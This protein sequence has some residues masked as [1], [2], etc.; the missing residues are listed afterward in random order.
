LAREH[1]VPFLVAA[2]FS[3]VD[4]SIPDGSH[5]PIEERD[6]AEVTHLAGKRVAPQGMRVR[7]PAFDVTPAANIT[8][9]ITERG[10][11]RPPFGES[12]R[13]LAGAETPG[14][15]HLRGGTC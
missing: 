3:T 5:I 4:L 8:A 12:L 10:I 11:A 1:G 15:G 6:P 13:E 14:Q 9:I 2:P 7:N